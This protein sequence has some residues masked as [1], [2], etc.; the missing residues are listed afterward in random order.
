MQFNVIGVDFS[1]APKKNKPIII[2]TGL[3]KPTLSN[4][5]N[6]KSFLVSLDDFVELD[7]LSKFEDF[8]I[9]SK[10]WVGGFDLPFGMPRSLIENFHWP[11]SWNKFVNFFC[12]SNKAYLKD[13]FKMWCDSR[14]P[15][16]KFA[17]RK[18][19]KIA[20]SSPAMRWTNPPVAW[21]MHS[22]ILRMVNAGILFPAHCYP[23]SSEEIYKKVLEQSFTLQSFKIALETY[24]AIT[25]RII[26]KN[27]YKSDNKRKQNLTRFNCRKAILFGLMRDEVGLNIKL[28]VSEKM[29]QIILKDGKGDFLDSTICMLQ[30]ASLI[31]KKDFGIPTDV[32]PLEGWIFSH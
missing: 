6:R 19:D 25:A 8:L 24:P 7:D 17:W 23:I 3:L 2:A 16:Q 4:L 26:T 11:I 30:A 28:S 29:S 21:M 20:K 12:N 18:T 9:R 27:S 1:S 10:S 31:Q 5:S 22:G 13:C 15:G 14:P 32:D